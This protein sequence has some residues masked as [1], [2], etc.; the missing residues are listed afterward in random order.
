[1]GAGTELCERAIAGP[2]DLLIGSDLS[3]SVLPVARENLARANVRAP[4]VELVRGDATTFAP[5][6]RASLIITN[7]P[8]G[9][10]VQRTANLAPMLDRFLENAAV[11]LT[12]GGRLVWISPFPERSEVVARRSG[13]VLT[14]S[15]NVDMGG[16]S[17][18]MQA[19][20]RGAAQGVPQ[21]RPGSGEYRFGLGLK[22]P[23]K[24]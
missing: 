20:R 3:S 13:L 11:R 2:F 5:P 10:R 8:L 24:S 18:R 23:E 1:V 12:P 14:F 16:F 17:A 7:P 22:E 4:L 6:G 21:R 9:R 15:Q 19:F